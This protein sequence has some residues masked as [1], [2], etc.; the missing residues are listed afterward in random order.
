MHRVAEVV[1]RAL[2]GHVV[3]LVP[4]P[5]TLP[6]KRLRRKMP[7]VEQ[8]RLI[9]QYKQDTQTYLDH[10]SASYLP[11]PA[12]MPLPG[13]E[14]CIAPA[15][16]PGLGPL[17]MELPP[18][19]LP[20]VRR[21][22]LI[23]T[24]C[25]GVGCVGV[26]TFCK[27]R[28]ARGR[29]QSYPPEQLIARAAQAAR[30]GVKEIWLTGEDV[31][32]YGLDL[33][34]IAPTPAPQE[35]HPHHECHCGGA[36]AEA[37]AAS[38]DHE[39]H[40]GTEATSTPA[41]AACTCGRTEGPC[42]CGGAG[43]VRL[44]AEPVHV[45]P[46]ERWSLP[47]LVQKMSEVLPKDVMIRC[48]HTNPQHAHRNLAETAAMLRLPNVYSFLHVPVQAG[49]DRVLNHMKR[50]Y[51]AQQFRHVIETL[52]R[53]VP[54]V[55]IATDIICGYSNEG[56]EDFQESVQLVRDLRFPILNITQMY[57]R[58][59]TPAFEMDRIPSDIVKNRSRRLTRAC[60]EVDPFQHLVGQVQPALFTEISDC[61]RFLAGHL[62]NYVQ[63][64]L[65]CVGVTIDLASPE[66]ANACAKFP[67]RTAA[68]AEDEEDPDLAAHQEP[69]EEKEEGLVAPTAAS[70]ELDFEGGLAVGPRPHDAV[71]AQ[72]SAA[73]VGAA[74]PVQPEMG[75]W[76]TVRLVKAT[77]YYVFAE[78]VGPTPAVASASQ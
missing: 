47:K 78:R 13:P 21:N 24:L 30:E 29:L 27:T 22:P 8:E 33:P 58:P 16:Q 36:A 6:P 40:C 10:A 41:P 19:D 70:R 2:E 61:G 35:A 28:F 67:I 5:P 18:L 26:C 50:P 44:G 69:L 48:G 14:A 4:T 9:S 75:T 60:C 74:A 54:N 53:E 23:E 12:D 11:S 31:G 15:G 20:K 64:L 52:R 34:P 17:A 49:S 38:P 7:T 3:R 66:F 68:E 37:P 25:V 71:P 63:V 65:P 77:R 76:V 32:G 46:G 51:S 39:C 56:E 42:C 73:G 59:G 57:P 62:K 72:T 55:T 1:T 45:G 43:A